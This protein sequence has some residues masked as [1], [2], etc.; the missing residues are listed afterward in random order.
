MKK[1]LPF[2]LLAAASTGLLLA[3][4]SEEDPMTPEER[5]RLQQREV[6]AQKIQAPG[7]GDGLQ[8]DQSEKDD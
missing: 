2:A 7:S 5:A 8:M 1:F 4:C 6:P 3:G